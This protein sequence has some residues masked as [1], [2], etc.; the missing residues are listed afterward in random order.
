MD[1]NIMMDTV[2]FPRLFHPQLP[3]FNSDRRT[4]IT[5]YSRT[6]RPP[7]YFL[8]DFGLSDIFDPAQGRT[9][10]IPVLSGDRTVPE[11]QHNMNRRHEV[12][13]TDVYYIGNMIRESFLQVGAH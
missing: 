8:I 7:K 2:M 1:L 3:E 4:L 13:P 6:W 11:F 9:T 10:A 5:G 12:Y